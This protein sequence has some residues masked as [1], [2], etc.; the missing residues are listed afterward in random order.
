MRLAF[1]F[2]EMLTHRIITKKAHTDKNTSGHPR[3]NQETVKS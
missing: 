1:I 2:I 3:G